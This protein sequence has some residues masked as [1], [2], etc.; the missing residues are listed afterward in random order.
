MNSKISALIVCLVA[1]KLNLYYKILLFEKR[2]LLYEITINVDKAVTQ[3]GV[4]F[5]ITIGATRHFTHYAAS[6]SKVVR[7]VQNVVAPN[8]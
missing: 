5:I 6:F 1:G 8:F 2:L 4:D 7:T 3:P